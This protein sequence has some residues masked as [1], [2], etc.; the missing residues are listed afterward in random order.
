MLK[1]FEK[2]S[3]SIGS[4][5]TQVWCNSS[6]AHGC[7]NST[8][9]SFM[10]TFMKKAA[11]FNVLYGLQVP[12]QYDGYSCRWRVLI[13]TKFIFDSYFIEKAKQVGVPILRDTIE[14][15]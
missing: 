1:G 12:Q 2:N 6:L 15:R 5:C 13:N 4:M 10:E 8:S 9:L 14:D 3:Y 11:C 7:K